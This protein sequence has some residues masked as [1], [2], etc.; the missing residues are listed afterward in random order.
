[1]NSIHNSM[2]RLLINESYGI[3][4]DMIEDSDIQNS[5]KESAILENQII[6]PSATCS[7]D[8]ALSNLE[9]TM[10]FS[11]DIQKLP[12]QMSVAIKKNP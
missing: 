11:V 9:D 12:R 8:V 10:K 1:M 3:G 7:P 6:S 5:E 2:R 4:L